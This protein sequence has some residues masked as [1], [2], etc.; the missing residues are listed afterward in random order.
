MV[1]RFTLQPEGIG[2]RCG[3]RRHKCSTNV[4]EDGG[5]FA[6]CGPCCRNCSIWCQRMLTRQVPTNTRARS[7]RCHRSC[8]KSESYHAMPGHRRP[9]GTCAQCVLIH[10]SGSTHRQHQVL[11]LQREGNH[12]THARIHCSGN[13]SSA[14]SDSCTLP[15]RDP[16]VRNCS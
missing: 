12:A 2:Q 8:N 15:R 13:T 11:G 6:T 5:S 7:G 1:L 16:V 9:W 4:A 10:H 3:P 14:P